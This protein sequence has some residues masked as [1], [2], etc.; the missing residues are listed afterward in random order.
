MIPPATAALA[1][2]TASGRRSGWRRWLRIAFV[3]WGT[4]VMLW[5]ANSMRTRGVDPTLLQSDTQVTVEETAEFLAFRPVQPRGAAGLIF[6]CGSGVAAPAYA[7]LLRPIAEAGFTVH[8]VKLPWRFAP[9]PA[10][11]DAAL[12]RGREGLRRYPATTAWIISGHSLGGALACRFVQPVPVGVAALVLVGTTHPKADDLSELPIPVTK[13]YGTADGVAPTARVRANRHLL[14]ARTRWIE[15]AGA[16]HS[17]FGHYGR[18]LFDGTP[19]LS[20]ED[21]QAAVRA[22]LL[23]QM[24]TPPLHS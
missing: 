22:V 20:R 12:A 11:R 16:N 18:Q 23:E 8:I 2:Q 21:Q 6:F 9:L 1:T 7:P 13:I 10:H 17:Q 4:G 3:L 14:P 5:L 19:T 24:Q 15:L